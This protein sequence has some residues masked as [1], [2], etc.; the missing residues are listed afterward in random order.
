MKI[1]IDFYSVL[2]VLPDAPA[3]VVVAA[4]RALA[5]LYHPDRWKGDIAEATARM[6]DINVAYS[7]LGDAA[8]RREYDALRM[9][10]HSNYE[11]EEDPKDATFDAALEEM[12]DRWQI[13]VNVFPDL[14]IIRKRLEKT[15]HRLAFAFV[16]VILETKQFQNSE[17]VAEAMEKAFLERYFGVNER[18]LAYAKELIKYGMKDAVAALNKYVDVLGSGIDPMPVIAKIE[19]DFKVLEIRR[20]NAKVQESSFFDAKT[21]VNIEKMRK[22]VKYYRIANDALKL[23]YLLRY[24]VEITGGGFFK[25]NIYTVRTS[26]SYEIVASLK[27]P[28]E[29]TEWVVTSLC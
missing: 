20:A 18:V 8:K 5:S 24:R 25:P 19:K 7:V 13:A 26:S 2:G 28:Q 3:V 15:A 21:L 16:T 4:Y 9:S 17:A 10:N 6:S 12:N 23:A 14:A 29:F 22:D 11:N 27:S 1:D